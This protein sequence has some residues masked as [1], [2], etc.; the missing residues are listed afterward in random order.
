MNK[1]I[2]ILLI[3]VGVSLQGCIEGCESC[4]EYF[5]C[6]MCLGKYLDTEINQC[7]VKAPEEENCK[8]YTKEGC[9]MCKDG[10]SM[11]YSSKKCVPGKIE[12]CYLSYTENQVE[13]CLACVGKVPADD[14]HECVDW[15]Q[16]EAY[17]NCKIAFNLKGI[18]DASCVICLDGYVIDTHKKKCV[19]YSEA[20][21]KQEDG[22][23]AISSFGVCDQ[24]D[25]EKNYYMPRVGKCTLM[26]EGVKKILK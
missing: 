7:V 8:L 12:N 6:S 25:Y 23:I 17:N 24:C 9:F 22:C 2:L 4:D 1:N 21:V 14:L 13:S 20:G 16:T 11:D 18:I 19:P 15:P 26:K 3:I 5:R 10:L